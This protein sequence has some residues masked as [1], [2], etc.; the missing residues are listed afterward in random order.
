MGSSAAYGL[1]LSKL[2]TEAFKIYFELD[3]DQNITQFADFMETLIHIKPSGCDVQII[4]S[5]GCIKFTKT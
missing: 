3:K 5:G 2:I 4:N 1:V